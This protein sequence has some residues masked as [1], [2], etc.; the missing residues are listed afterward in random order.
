M[1]NVMRRVTSPLLFNLCHTSECAIDSLLFLEEEDFD[2]D[3]FRLRQFSQITDAIFASMLRRA[4]HRWTAKPLKKITRLPQ[5]PPFHRH[6]R[7]PQPLQPVGSSTHGSKKS[8]DFG[9]KQVV[10]LLNTGGQANTH[11][12]RGVEVQ[13]DEAVVTAPPPPGSVDGAVVA[14]PPKSTVKAISIPG[15]CCKS[16]SCAMYTFS[17]G[18]REIVEIVKEHSMSEGDCVTIYIPSLARERQTTGAR[19]EYLSQQETDDEVD[20]ALTI[21]ASEQV[22]TDNTAAAA[23]VAAAV[24]T[25]AAGAAAA[26]V[27]VATRQA[28]AALVTKDQAA[29]TVC[30]SAVSAPLG[31][32][33]LVDADGRFLALASHMERRSA[34]VCFEVKCRSCGQKIPLS[35]MEDGSHEDVCTGE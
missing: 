27:A 9:E 16:P 15:R 22:D 26:A 3:S 17:D 13:L 32:P 20:R 19:L 14:V 33:S 11:E 28:T 8:A 30:D 24:G 18:R 6:S 4:W 35:D 25:D 5:Q 2:R 29:I 1:D 34:S 12:A 23:E 21:K 31:D 10:C 7:L